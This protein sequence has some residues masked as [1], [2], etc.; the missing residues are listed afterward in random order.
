MAGQGYT[1]DATGALDTG[2]SPVDALMRIVDEALSGEA[3][4]WERAELEKEGRPT[5]RVT[6]ELR[7]QAGDVEVY[8]DAETGGYSWGFTYEPDADLDDIDVEYTGRDAPDRLQNAFSDVVILD[9]EL[10]RT[11]A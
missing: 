11:D 1:A 6:M 2:R 10:G 9:R 8:V 3:D 5:T 7:G 4:G